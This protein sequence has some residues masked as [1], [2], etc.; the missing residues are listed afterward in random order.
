[1]TN[2]WEP[3]AR[4]CR[5]RC[6]YRARGRRVAWAPGSGVRYPSTV[7]PRWR[8]SPRTIRTTEG[9]EGAWCTGGAG[10]RGRPPGTGPR[11]LQGGCWWKATSSDS[12][13]AGSNTGG[14][15]G[16]VPSWRPL[17]AWPRWAVRTP[18]YSR[19]AR[20]YCSPCGRSTK[21]WWSPRTTHRHRS[22]TTT[23]LTPCDRH[24]RLR[25]T[26]CGRRAA[27]PSPSPTDHPLA[28]LVQS[29]DDILKVCACPTLTTSCHNWGRVVSALSPHSL[30]STLCSPPP[31]LHY[32]FN[33]NTCL[34][35]TYSSL[36]LFPLVLQF[37]KVLIQHRVN[38]ICKKGLRFHFLPRSSLNINFISLISAIRF[39]DLKQHL[40]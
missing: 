36:L 14:S 33:C 37:A 38:F 29:M 17:E 39:R 23:A 6:R 32:F 7:R 24:K 22:L 15:W 26:D 19:R 34:S 1:M 30:S 12:P 21:P 40:D 27:L 35:L 16:G 11:G 18:H 4:I 8:R 10:V 25:A 28:P 9:P 3:W 13:L 20:V 5:P 31:T 2:L